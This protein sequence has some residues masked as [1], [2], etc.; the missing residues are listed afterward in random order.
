MPIQ[1]RVVVVISFGM[2][3]GYALIKVSSTK[4]SCCSDLLWNA[5][6]QY[7]DQGLDFKIL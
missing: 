6:R 1:R 7:S 3:E 4:E 2:L 5:R